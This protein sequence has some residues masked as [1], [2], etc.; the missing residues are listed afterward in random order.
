MA[1][2]SEQYLKRMSDK[3]LVLELET[4]VSSSLRGLG[5]TAGDRAQSLRELRSELRS[6]RLN[7]ARIQKF[8]VSNCTVE[9]LVGGGPSS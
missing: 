6:R 3:S 4:M 2:Y 8:L 1:Q 5:I 7:R 9:K